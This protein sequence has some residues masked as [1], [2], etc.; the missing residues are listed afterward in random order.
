MFP[1]TYCEP[2]SLRATAHPNACAIIFSSAGIPMEF[3]ILCDAGRS[4]QTMGVYRSI[5]SRR[6]IF[7]L[8]L[9][10]G[11]PA[12]ARSATMEDSAKELARKI[13]AAL[14]AR[15]NISCEIRNRSSLR[16]DEV[17][18]V[19]KTIK[20]EL[21]AEGVHL[22]EGGAASSVMVTLSEN[23]KE[24]VW[25]AEIVAGGAS[26]A[27]LL[28]V[29]RDGAAPA[30]SNAMHVTVRSEKFWDGP[31][32][33]LDADEVH[34][35]VGKSWLLLLSPLVFE[36]QDL[37]TGMSSTIDISAQ[38]FRNRDPWGEIGV[39]PLRE[40][41]FS[42]GDTVCI[43]QLEPLALTRCSPEGRTIPFAL[44]PPPPGQRIELSIASVCGVSDQF[45]ATSMRDYSQTDTLQVFHRESTGRVP[46]S[47]ELEFPGP[48]LALHPDRDAPRAIVRNLA[49]GN[50]EAYR[51]AISCGE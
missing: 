17:A 28:A 20:T 46:M 36:V 27:V 25:T 31:Q 29:P 9:L 13:V 15:D 21:A 3:S 44:F 11:F 33:I 19:D 37:Q 49:T 34:N 32:Q 51:L 38:Y 5:V 18:R 10:I 45:L 22:A 14:P 48:V 41:G 30:A 43:V 4:I 8:S 35:G 1:D 2:L 16:P 42:T 39:S 6:A 26:R 7:F 23:W 50:Y 24:F 40:T 47:G 12:A